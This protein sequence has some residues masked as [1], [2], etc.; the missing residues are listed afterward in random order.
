MNELLKK[1]NDIII[2][3]SDK[4]MLK[5]YNGE[6]L[7]YTEFDNKVNLLA[8][9]L[10]DTFFGEKIIPVISN[11][12]LDYLITMIACWKVN[13]IYFP[14]NYNT[15]PIKFENTLLSIGSKSILSRNYNEDIK[16]INKIYF[17]FTKKE[18]LKLK[19]DE[20][21]NIAYILATSGTTGN[22]KMVQI[23]F[24]NLY[25]LLESMNEIVPFT[26]EDTF[27]IS[28]PPQFDVNFHEMLS[29]ILGEG[30]LQ[31]IEPGTPIQQ[32][33]RLVDI[34]INDN[35]THV[36][37]SP[38]TLK[39]ILS[40]TKDKIGQSKLENIILAG[41][42]L[43]VNV[44][45]NL[46]SLIPNANIWNCYGPTE[47]TVY[48]TGYNIRSHVDN[49]TVPIGTALR[50]ADIKF[51]KSN[52][53]NDV[54]GEIL[55]GG[56]GVGLGYLNN[57]ILTKEKFIS[58]NNVKYYRTGD[59]GFKQNGLIYFQG[60]EDRQVKIN[61]IRIELDEIEQAIQS[62]LDKFVN[63]SV[64]KIDNNLVLFSDQEINYEVLKKSIINRLPEYMIPKYFC[65]VDEMKV[66]ASNKLDTEYLKNRFN[67]QFIDDKLER[68][69]LHDDIYKIISDI[70][71]DSL[72][73]DDTNLLLL[74]SMDSLTQIELIMS[75]EEV[76]KID[77]PD[78]FIK[79]HKTIKEIRQ[80]IESQNYENILKNSD[81]SPNLSEY[82]LDNVYS[83]YKNIRSLNNYIINQGKFVVK[84]TSY[85]QKAY[86]VDDFKQVLELKV[87]L[88]NSF[89][90]I[91]QINELIYKLIEKN[92]LLRSII[93]E[94]HELVIY[95]P[96]NY[97]VSAISKSLI[98]SLKNKI[99][100]DLEN[101]ILNKILW[102]VYF[103]DVNSELYFFIN[104][105]ITDQYSISIIE[106]DILT[107]VEGMDLIIN[108]TFSDFVDLINYNSSM[109]TLEKILDKGF[110]KVEK[111]NFYNITYN[112]HSKYFS[113]KTPYKNNYDN[114]VYGNYVL[115]Q[116]LAK[117]QNRNNV[118]GSTI[119]NIRE[120]KINDCNVSF[121]DTFGDL[122]STIPV[123][124]NKGDS[125]EEFKKNFDDIYDYFLKGDN[126][127]NTIYKNYPNI[128]S[129]FKKYELYLDDNLKF[130][131]NFLGAIREKDLDKIVRELESEQYSLN[132][133]SNIKLYITFFLC[134]DELIFVP[135]TQNLLDI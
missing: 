48:A 74:S 44:A 40:M 42:V 100:K 73:N 93:N 18:S 61:G 98:T 38:T 108:N 79:R 13:K 30:L 20:I 121:N 91:S 89:K 43:P 22:P 119:I 6:I 25:W 11:D 7:T 49:L 5:L 99:I 60:R 107:L 129:K 45:N 52:E 78:D 4:P 122:H 56:G 54:E 96:Y 88:P 29:F 68:N 117:S 35:I 51:Y 2:K 36:A 26:K 90:S 10:I 32:F 39:K 124:F 85:L 33:K 131:N 127:N 126:I 75:L 103:D 84:D 1:Y 77:L 92:E 19:N 86:L 110:D 123:I 21:T 70:F 116:L 115:S 69:Y 14:I 83:I 41:E 3:R 132:N 81:I 24:N 133:F 34:L 28:T 8:N 97:K 23:S 134:G 59:L 67:Q 111:D 16:N 128:P 118:S 94:K 62:Q 130:S 53:I 66:T 72:V 12:N 112:N 58:F 37:L 106:K 46:T 55:I 125:E 105:L 104:H 95:Q 17:D 27:I 109:N 114:I 57:E 47:T 65:K 101:E 71:S 64:V 50:G 80:Y 31:F 76:F 87:S 135:I 120:F 9:H 15:P 102:E 113:V 82:Q 63:F